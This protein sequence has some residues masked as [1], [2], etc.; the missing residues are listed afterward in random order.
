M[1]SFREPPPRPFLKWAG[2]KRQLLPELFRAV[3]AAGPFEHYHEPFFGGGALFFA[4]ARAGKLPGRSYLADINKNLMDA[5]LGVRDEIDAV[6]YQLKVHKQRH[7][8]EY[9]YQ[10]RAH[11]PRS[12]PNRAAR[13]IYLNRT[14]YNGL[15]RENSKGQF[16]A[17]FG[18]YKNPRICD[19]E[20]LRAVSQTLKNMDITVADF[21][22][23]LDTAQAGDL[24]YFDPPYA[25]LSKTAS[26]TAY[27]KGGF[28]SDAQMRLAEVCTTLARRRVKVILS[29]SMT[30]LVKDLYQ[31]FHIH[32]VLANR[33]I[34]SRGHQRGKIAEAL[35]TNF[36]V[37]PGHY[38]ALTP[39]NGRSVLPEVTAGKPEITSVKQWLSENDY[40]DVAA[41]IDEV[42]TAWKSQGKRTRRNWW[43]ILAGTKDGKP[44]VV[45]GRTFPVL[46]TAQLR[47]GLQETPN[48]L[49]RNRKEPIPP[50]LVPGR[51]RG[52]N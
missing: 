50:V 9:F 1:T 18:R 44:R 49:C 26:F 43:E 51:W 17:P 47:Q 15:Y 48:A 38:P 42:E 3:E 28:T 39:I 4:L 32:E 36:P 40:Q 45:A 30:E 24:V 10:V 13:I 8:E 16:N 5:Y 12:L 2:G 31:D 33:A 6:I 19:E 27:S 34:N 52:S 21:S 41:L 25:P 46:R 22:C 11:L 37:D 20:N 7:G 29:N 23:V 35:I 14:C